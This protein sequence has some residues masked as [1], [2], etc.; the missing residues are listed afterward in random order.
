[1][2]RVKEMAQELV[3]GLNIDDVLLAAMYQESLLTNVHRQSI[4]SMLETGGPPIDRASYFVNKV[5]FNY[6]CDVFE[7]QLAKLEVILADHADVANRD[8]AKKMCKIR[9]ECQSTTV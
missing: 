6:P 4:Y 5:L 8:F 1:M 7:E 3:E 2:K 9:K